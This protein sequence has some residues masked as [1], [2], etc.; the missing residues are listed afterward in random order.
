MKCQTPVRHHAWWIPHSS[1]CSQSHNVCSRFYIKG[2]SQIKVTKINTT[3]TKRTDDLEIKYK[4]IKHQFTQF[5][6]KASHYLFST[7][8]YVAHANLKERESDKINICSSAM[9][10]SNH[11][12]WDALVSYSE[13]VTAIFQNGEN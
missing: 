7:W 1:A 12:F 6:H 11:P 13:S 5:L 4:Q 9:P 3:C 10:I 2:W 8:P